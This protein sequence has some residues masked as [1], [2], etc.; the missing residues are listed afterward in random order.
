MC[1]HFHTT[2]T[3]K[4]FILIYLQIYSSP[5]RLKVSSVNLKVEPHAIYVP[6]L[7]LLSHPKSPHR[8][9]FL[10]VNSL[11]TSEWNLTV[12]FRLEFRREYA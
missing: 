2:I 10:S 6:D 3:S 12:T 4:T 7:L 8:S 1:I 11:L 9:K 5:H